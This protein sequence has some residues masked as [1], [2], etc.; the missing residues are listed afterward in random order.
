MRSWAAAMTGEDKATQI[1]FQR[2]PIS[3]PSVELVER[4]PYPSIR[5]R[6]GNELRS[7]TAVSF[8]ISQHKPRDHQQE[9]H[10]KQPPWPS[11]REHSWLPSECGNSSVPSSCSASLPV[12]CAT[13]HWQ[14]QRGT[15]ASS[16]PSLWHA[17][18]PSS[19]LSLCYR[20]C[21]R[22]WPSRATSPCSSCG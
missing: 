10:Q 1:G 8:R 2:K 3:I 16:M 15:A 18:A 11:C 13:W 17:S 6:I 12:F 7:S 5:N 20:S 21:T 19:R 9:V 14:E 22:S 4:I